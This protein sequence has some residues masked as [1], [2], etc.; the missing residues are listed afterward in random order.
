MLV[1]GKIHSPASKRD[2]F[3]FKPQPLFRT[4]FKSQFDFARSAD[5]PLPGKY[6]GRRGSKE[7]RYGP[8][9]KRIS[10]GRGYLAVRGDT[11]L[12]D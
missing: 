6:M 11:S 8:V 5:D 10:R 1:A 3:Q 2:A 12:W 9:I 4:C 7:P